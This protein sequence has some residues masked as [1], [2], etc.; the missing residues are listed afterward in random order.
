M[1]QYSNYVPGPEGPIPIQTHRARMFD[2]IRVRLGAS[3]DYQ[4]VVQFATSSD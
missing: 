1:I 4:F 2:I 3:H